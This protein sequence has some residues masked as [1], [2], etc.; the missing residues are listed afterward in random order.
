[1]R[2]L[3][4]ILILTL[5]FQTLV[6]ADDIRD[7][8]IEGM[9]IGDS[10]LEHFDKKKIQKKN[11][12]YY[13]KSKKYAGISIKKKSLKRYENTQFTFDPKTYKIY[14][15]SG[16]INFPNDINSCLNK[17]KD[18]VKEISTLLPSAESYDKESSHRY[19]KTG[20]SINYTTYFNLKDKSGGIRIVCVDWREGIKSN[21]NILLVDK[22]MISV[23][24]KNYI[25]FLRK[26]AY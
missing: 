25:K 3:L 6:K 1:M 13:P 17:K 23:R 14:S 26:E 16:K 5:S 22:L 9:S 8:Q 2:R 20:Q 15:I 7:F 10:M 11:L 19:D 21:N 18:V 4:L 24:H 12:F